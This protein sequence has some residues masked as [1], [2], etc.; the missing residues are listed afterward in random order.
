MFV[1]FL[2]NLVFATR[3]PILIALA[4][5]TVWTGYYAVQLRLDAGFD[6]QLPKAHPYIET[7]QEYRD[8]LFGSNRIIIVLKAE[9]GTIWTPE[10][11]GKLKEVT[12]DIFFL[13]GV[14]KRTV[15]SLWTPNT[16]YFEI[17]EEG[18]RADNV[19]PGTVTAETMT[20]EDLD[21]IQNNVIRGNYVGRLVANDFS[22]AMIVAELQE[23]VKVENPETGQTEFK[24]LDYFELAD[25]LESEIRQKHESEGYTI[26]IIGF[27]KLIG[28][29]ADGAGSVLIFMGVAFLITALLVYWYSQSIVLTIAPLLCSLTSLVWQF[30]ILKLGGY[31]L[32]PLAV[33]VPFLVFAIGVSHGV[34]QINLFSAEIESG[35][36]SEAAARGAFS[37]LLI[38]G[39]MALVTD[40]VGFGTLYFVQIPMIQ[41]L[42]I[43][44]SIGVLLKIITNLIMLPILVSYFT[45]DAGYVRRVQKARE[46]RLKIMRVL[47]RIAEPRVAVVTFTISIV[48]LGVGIWQS[49]GRHVGDLHAGAPELKPEARYNQDSRL[50]AE[51]YSIGL[52]L[53]TV[54]IETPSESCI[55]YEYMNWLGEFS[56]AMENVPGVLSVAS[57]ATAAK[58]TNAGWNEGNLK[59]RTL[60]R[61]QF[62]LVQATSPIPTSSGLI[63]NDCTVL[64]LFIFTEDAKA[65][66]LKRVVEAV[67]DW[68]AENGYPPALNKGIDNKDGTWTLTRQDLDG[69]QFTTPPLITTRQSFGVKLL[70]AP[71]QGG[72]GEGEEASEASGG[73]DAREVLFEG[74]FEF[75]P[76]REGETYDM[77]LRDQLPD[78]PWSDAQRI[79]L[80]DVPASTYIRLAS[81]NVGVIAATNDE[82]ETSELPMMLAV[83]AVIIFM[84]FLT[85]RDWRATLACCLPLTVA[86]FLGYWFMKE[87]EI[88][89]KVATL[90]VMVLAVGLG[91]DY[92]FY[93]YNRVQYHLAEGMN[94]TD[95]YKQTML[96]TGMAVVFVA[97]TMAVGVS[98]WVF[99]DLK[100]QA[101]MG[102]LLFLMFMTNMIMAIT[103]LPALAVVLDMLFPRK[104]PVKAPTGAFAH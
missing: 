15:Q 8:T 32:D 19:I 59:W 91:V 18:F 45:F 100:F 52:N 6:K 11:M 104:K 30:G 94:I 43:T 37:G 9:E 49:Q 14:D 96:E 80:T 70:G 55:K 66:T 82:I 73:A 53:L 85:Y 68:R 57:A 17:T 90:P 92:A 13:P 69:L 75:E 12:D 63:N 26:H 93:I 72:A 89:L 4:A 46:F 58:Q 24:E 77:V 41:E 3:I 74:T 98:T 2:E 29:I 38:P 101:D 47:G 62:S 95:S 67:K 23:L 79:Q 54:V 50:I 65:E 7:F 1:K 48:L 71:Q 39:T 60:P 25:K 42:A 21:Q 36:D 87:L 40:L 44:A 61:N 103:A 27:A 20:D 35:K 31:G 10:F 88:G 83:Y 99:S 81:G 5:L 78:A 56:W 22:S 33:L 84:V 102:L 64:P 34:Q 51:S 28:D 86:T 76:P 16:R 97:L